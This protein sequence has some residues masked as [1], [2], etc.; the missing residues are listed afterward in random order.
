MLVVIFISII[1]I[2]QPLKVRPSTLAVTFIV[3][4]FIKYPIEF[5]IYDIKRL[6]NEHGV[7]ELIE[8]VTTGLR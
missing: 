6:V 5:E 3:K 8:E 1:I 4:A 2:L 7:A